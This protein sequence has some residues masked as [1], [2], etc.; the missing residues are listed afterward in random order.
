MFGICGG[1]QMLGV[2]YGMTGEW[3]EANQYKGNPWYGTFA[4][5]NSFCKGK[6]QDKGK[7]IFV[8][9][10]AD[11][12]PKAEVYLYEIDMGESSGKINWVTLKKE[13][14]EEKETFLDGCNKDNIYGTYVHGF[15]DSEDVIRRL[16]GIFVKEKGHD[17]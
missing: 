17:S 5:G 16:E 12:R 6:K 2:T 7:G 8:K 10:R 15:F 9:Q 13:K 1:Y 14:G 4:Y 3:T 11:W